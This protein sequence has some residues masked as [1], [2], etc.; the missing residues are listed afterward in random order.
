MA[1]DLF[2]QYYNN[3]TKQYIY[4]NMVCS[5][6]L[7]GDELKFSFIDDNASISSNNDILSKID[8]SKIKEHIV[9]WNNTN[10][11][12]EPYSMV[13]IKGFSQ[14]L[15]Y[16]KNKFIKI[17][18]T[19]LNLEDYLYYIGIE[20]NIKCYNNGHM[21]STYVHGFG[22]YDS[23]VNVLESVQSMLDDLQIPVTI[24]IENYGIILTSAVLGYEY[25]ISTDFHT[26]TVK[27]YTVED[28]LVEETIS[29]YLYDDKTS[30]V[31]SE[32]YRNGAFKGVVLA[33]IYPKYKNNYIVDS[34]R[35]LKVAHIRNRI[36]RYIP[37]TLNHY[38]V[39]DNISFEV[40]DG[41]NDTN[42]LSRFN[43]WRNIDSSFNDVTEWNEWDM[44]P[45]SDTR[46]YPGFVRDKKLPANYHDNI[47]GLYGFINWAHDTNSWTNIGALYSILT[48][49][50][51]VTVA[52][53]NLIDSFVVYNPNPFPI[54][55]ACLTYA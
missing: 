6:A 55:I 2:K 39:Y 16:Q 41:Y 50:D 13:Y 21:T 7:S 5:N 14:G 15:S 33:P 42:E 32:K 47:T 29:M 51:D 36:D 53:K 40:I 10:R 54:Q 24:S 43:K 25:Y 31:P 46:W 34:A 1:T 44:I 23:N 27:L 20:F 49:T 30:Y 12:I 9:E 4:T 19:I 18:E 3:P 48:P 52:D 37:T 17:P 22:D 38:L 11:T 28:A 8:L 45:E 26:N 35:S